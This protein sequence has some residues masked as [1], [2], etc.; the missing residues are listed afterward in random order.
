MSTPSTAQSGQ[1]KGKPGDGKVDLS[2]K[3]RLDA[4]AEH[5]KAQ[6]ANANADRGNEEGILSQVVEKGNNS[7]HP[8]TYIPPGDTRLI[9]LAWWSCSVPI[10]SGCRSHPKPGGT[11]VVHASGWEWRWR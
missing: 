1:P 4:A 11:G 6:N 5:V 9:W 3:E 7:R 8:D 2:Y 10:C